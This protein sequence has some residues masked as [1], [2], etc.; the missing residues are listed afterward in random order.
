MYERDDGLLLVRTFQWHN[1]GQVPD[2]I[3]YLENNQHCMS[4]SV[5][6]DKSKTH[7]NPNGFGL[8]IDIE[9]AVIV[10]AGIKNLGSGSQPTKNAQSVQTIVN[11]CAISCIHKKFQYVTFFLLLFSF[12]QNDRNQAESRF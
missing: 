11:K 6:G 7:V 5:I 8:V 2:E 10:G 12:S 1:F 4:T 9:R 3:N